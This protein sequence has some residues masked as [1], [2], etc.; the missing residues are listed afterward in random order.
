MRTF[1][2]TFAT[3]AICATAARAVAQ[4]SPPADAAPAAAAPAPTAPAPAVAPA[5]AAPP[6]PTS[7]TIVS[8]P[9]PAAATT[10]AGTGARAPS[11]RGATV[12]GVLPW[13]GVGVGG[14]F[15]MPVG[16][17]P[18]LGQRSIRDNFALELG[19]DVLRWSYDFG[20]AGSGYS[21]TWTEILPVAGVMWNLWLSDRFAFYPKAQVGYAF[22]WFSGLRGATL[23]AYGG[24][25]ADGAVGALYNVG[26]GLSLRAEAGSAG[27]RLGAGWLF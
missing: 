13:G 27:L 4:A 18:L 1:I 21:Y 16:I 3:I 6:G 2:S 26:G 7:T 8:E 15:M 19:A 11:P 12:W 20:Y 17:P 10:A 23:A 22:G 14:R 24:T 25:F 5:P 9:P